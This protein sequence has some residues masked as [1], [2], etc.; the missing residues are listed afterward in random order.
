MRGS[1]WLRSRGKRLNPPN[2]INSPPINQEHPVDLDQ[3]GI[4]CPST[5]PTRPS[6]QPPRL[7]RFIKLNRRMKAGWAPSA[8]HHHST[9]IWMTTPPP[10]TAPMPASPGRDRG[11]SSRFVVMVAGSMLRR[12]GRGCGVSLE[13]TA[14]PAPSTA[15]AAP[16]R[17]AT[18]CYQTMISQ[19]SE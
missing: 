4:H 6:T 8:A 16:V 7:S 15:T 5:W 11:L 14:G 3:I 18:A 19:W 1:R 10:T 13:G 9:K 12:W 17:S 2:P